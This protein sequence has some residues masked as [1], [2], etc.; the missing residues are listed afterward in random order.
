[1]AVGCLTEVLLDEGFFSQTRSQH[2]SPCLLL[3][4]GVPSALFPLC[5]AWAFGWW[6]LSFQV[7]PSRKGLHC[8][9]LE[10]AGREQ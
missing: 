5:I 1:M 6:L 4:P 7:P 8:S 3:P 9:F 2:I 10:A